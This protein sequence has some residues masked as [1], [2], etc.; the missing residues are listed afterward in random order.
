MVALQNEVSLLKDLKHPHI[1]AYMG[2]DYID[3]CLYMYLEY[4]PGGSMAQVLQAFGAFEESLIADYTRQI[5]A[6]LV[7]LHHENTPP[8][9]HRDIKGAN[10]LVGLDAR[11][12]LADFGCSKR[13]QETMSY[14]LRGSV[15]WMAPEVISHTAY[16]R[17]A[18]VW[19][20]G[21]VLIEM[22]SAK[23]P[24]GRFD[25]QLAAM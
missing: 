9:V 19:S 22:G 14:T 18:D 20:F 13:S 8:V 23:V 10:I 16:G 25:N 1:V 24:W 15:P 6:G 5:L 3:S 12:K 11:V 4:M 2:H 7:Y 21:C 17:S